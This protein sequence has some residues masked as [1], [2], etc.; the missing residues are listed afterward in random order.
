[1]LFDKEKKGPSEYSTR[2]LIIV[3]LSNYLAYSRS[4]SFEERAKSLLS[5]L[6]DPSPPEEAQLP[7][8]ITS[9]YHPRPFRVW[10]KELDNLTK[11]VFWIFLHHT[12]I[13]PFPPEHSAPAA[14]DSGDVSSY[15][16]RHFPREHPP[17]PAAPY[18]GG[19]EW[20]ATTYVTAH[21]DLINGIIASLPS[22]DDRNAVRQQLKDSGFEKLMGGYLRTCKEKFYGSV[23]EALSVWIGAAR[24]DGWAYKDVKEG[25]P[26]EEM[27]KRSPQ[28][29]GGGGGGKNKGGKKA[30]EQ[31]APPRL[32]M[33]KL[34]LGAPKAAE[35]DSGGW[36]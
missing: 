7:G 5:H 29:S 34:D 8:F 33:P 16:A 36:F 25:P 1:M 4:S 30:G 3:L 6:R 13:I 31:A 17:V 24:E 28:K 10:N 32:E 11:E 22:R 23:H 2:T 20:E 15:R 14:M 27:V 18:I 19:V 26:R 35:V 9:I 12:N 21:L